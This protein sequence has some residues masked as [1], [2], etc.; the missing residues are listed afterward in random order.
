MTVGGRHCGRQ[1]TPQFLERERFCQYRVV[2]Q[3]D[4]QTRRAV[5][6]TE[7]NGR[8]AL[9][10]LPGKREHLFAADIHVQ[11]RNIEGLGFHRFE[12]L[13]Q[14]RHRGND[15]AAEY[16]EHIFEQHGDAAFILYEQDT[17]AG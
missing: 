3:V 14:V 10:K 4:R 16:V 7:N 6:G 5:S 15:F 9:D 11:D 12:G 2:P 1:G 17:Q 8:P 13:L